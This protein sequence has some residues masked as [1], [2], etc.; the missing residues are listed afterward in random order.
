MGTAIAISTN[1]EGGRKEERVFEKQVK[2][3]KLRS[4][5]NSLFFSKKLV[6]RN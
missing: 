1:Y 2:G 4:K 6:R 3:C 5:K